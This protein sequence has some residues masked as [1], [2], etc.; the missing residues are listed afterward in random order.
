M[1]TQSI[2][3]ELREMAERLE[4][5]VDFLR[6]AGR[7]AEST[8]LFVLR[9][10][11]LRTCDD[12]LTPQKSLPPDDTPLG[13]VVDLKDPPPWIVHVTFRDKKGTQIP[14][15]WPFPDEATARHAYTLAVESGQF[16]Q[17][18]RKATKKDPKDSVHLVS[19]WRIIPDATD[20]FGNPKVMYEMVDMPADLAA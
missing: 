10:T 3:G 18:I 6:A 2:T 9:R 4:N 8:D 13:L 1:D 11:L 14:A 16:R 17:V 5:M 15:T 20:R 7:L 12:L 19:V